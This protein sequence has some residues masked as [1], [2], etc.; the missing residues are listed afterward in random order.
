MGQRYLSIEMMT[1]SMLYTVSGK[2]H[3][4]GEYVYADG[5]KYIGQ[6]D[7]DRIHGEGTSWYPNGNKYDRVFS[8]KLS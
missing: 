3:G 5:T 8:G 4:K 2:R 6:W 7:N 1:A